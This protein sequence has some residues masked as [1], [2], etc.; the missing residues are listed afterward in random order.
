MMVVLIDVWPR[1][2]ECRLLSKADLQGAMDRVRPAIKYR[3]GDT[4]AVLHR[5]P[6]QQVTG[7]RKG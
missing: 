7:E 2:Q 1:W 3:K 4:L 5:N 6:S